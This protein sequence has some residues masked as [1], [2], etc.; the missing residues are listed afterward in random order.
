MCHIGSGTDCKILSIDSSAFLGLHSRIYAALGAE[1]KTHYT[2]ADLA[3][4]ARE[5]SSIATLVDS[6]ESLIKPLCIRRDKAPQTEPK[7]LVL[8]AKTLI[9]SD[10]SPT[11]TLAEKFVSLP[12][13]LV[14][15]PKKA[16]LSALLPLVS[17]NKLESEFDFL[18]MWSDSRLSCHCIRWI[19]LKTCLS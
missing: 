5:E 12:E 9:P 2:S 10:V 1:E 19:W 11:I 7:P 3:L 17:T 6:S 16:Y 15:L 18:D 8:L 4:I 14:S 13:T